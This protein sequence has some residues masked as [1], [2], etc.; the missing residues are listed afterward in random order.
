MTVEVN[1][2]VRIGHARMKSNVYVCGKG[3]KPNTAYNSWKPR[4]T[5]IGAVVDTALL[6]SGVSGSNISPVCS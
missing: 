3:T 2:Q 6:F 4:G 5:P 1:T